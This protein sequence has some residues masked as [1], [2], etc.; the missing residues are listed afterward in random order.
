LIS[1]GL[2]EKELRLLS[3]RVKFTLYAADYHL[4]ELKEFDTLEVW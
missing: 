2:E 3:D 4:N 1:K